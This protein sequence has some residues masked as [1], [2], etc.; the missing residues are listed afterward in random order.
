MLSLISL[1]DFSKYKFVL[2]DKN[3]SVA[4]SKNILTLLPA[5]TACLQLKF[6]VILILP[7]PTFSGIRAVIS[8]QWN[9]VTN[10]SF[11]LVFAMFGSFVAISVNHSL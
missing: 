4:F 5:N 8:V 11:D 2:T 7:C 3:K 9:T 1:T 10:K 6:D